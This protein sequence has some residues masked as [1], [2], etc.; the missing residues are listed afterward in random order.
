MNLCSQLSFFFYSSHSFIHCEHWLQCKV[1]AVHQKGANHTHTDDTVVRIQFRV[2]F[3]APRGH[4]GV[5][6]TRSEPQP[7]T[8]VVVKHNKAH[9]LS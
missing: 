3:F 1:P 6:L 4:R 5:P 8:R 2:Q 7:Q 9:T